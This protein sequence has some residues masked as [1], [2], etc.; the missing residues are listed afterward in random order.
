MMRRALPLSVA[1]LAVA[2]VSACGAGGGQTAGGGQ[3]LQVAAAFYPLEYAVS[4]V[5]GDHVSVLGLTK[6]GGEP[7]DLELSPKQVASVAGADLVV[8]E[9]GFQ[10]AVD[11]AVANTPKGNMLDVSA[12]ARLD[13][14]GTQEEAPAG[15][16][17]H[18]KERTAVDPHF[19]LDPMRYADVADAIAD[20]LATQDPAHATAYR[21]NA[22]AL[23]SDLT[24]L[25]NDFRTGLASC[26]VKELVTS[27]AA[28]GYLAR[29]YGLHQEGITGL[30]PEA[31]P[32]PAELARVVRHV[33]ESGARTIY[34]ETLV[35]RAV[36][37]TLARETGTKVAVLDPIE[38]I[39]SASAG[40]DY[41]AVMRANLATLRKGQ[42]CP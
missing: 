7:H 14:Q 13:L 24:G 11:A 19:W 36:A 26:R 2:A 42:D 8:Y 17:G 3:R 38:G 27:H 9:K 4:R 25:D 28:F 41:L 31:E 1:A 29:A 32:N 37:D 16:V 21:D 5:G 20:R 18:G 22:R 15:Q 6:P 23:R 39:T 35:S 40:T 34:A 33:R 12:A 30:D 10:P